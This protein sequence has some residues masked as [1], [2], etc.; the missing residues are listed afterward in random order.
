MAINGVA[1]AGFSNG[2][3][4]LIA[5][6]GKSTLVHGVI[7]TGVAAAL[8]GGDQEGT[9]PYRRLTG[10]SHF[11][12]TR[13]VDAAPV[14]KT[15]RSVPATYLGLW[16]TMRKA[17][18][19]TTEARTR[20]YGPGRFSFNV[21]GGRCDA[22]N[23]MGEVTVEMSFLPNVR[24]PCERCAGARF[25]PETLEITWRGRH[26]ADLLTLTFEEA[27]EVFKDFPRIAPSVRMM[28][29]VGLGYLSLGQPSPTLSGGEA[30]RLKLVTELGRSSREGATLY[31]LDEP[32]IGLHGEDVD[33]LL[34]V[35]QRLVERGD[36]V[37][38]IEHHLEFI[39]Q[40][41]YVVDLGPEGG[42]AGGRVVASGSP[43]QVAR[44]HR[45]SLTGAALRAMC[46]NLSH[47]PPQ[48]VR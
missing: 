34:E 43:A 15:P 10:A 46:N 47:S 2:R 48:A 20:G 5:V 39:A 23:G 13:V 31:V 26:A 36:T 25:A 6:A 21:A 16:D 33:R 7:H 4:F 32:T 1:G 19:S 30:Q 18:A 9:T 41:D 35:L 29:E 40:A 11:V 38:V 14:G 8:R 37:L 28:N 3:P 42:A 22:C 12:R 24:V 17:L 44:A 27:A 45:R